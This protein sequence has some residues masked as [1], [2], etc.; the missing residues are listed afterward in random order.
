MFIPK[1]F[2]FRI[3][4][5]QLDIN[6]ESLIGRDTT[7]NKTENPNIN[8]AELINSPEKLRSRLNELNI[9]L[10]DSEQNK[11]N[12]YN[13][14]YREYELLFQ[15]EAPAKQLQILKSS[16][17]PD[18]LHSSVQALK[19]IQK[20]INQIC[21]TTQN[22]DSSKLPEIELIMSEIL[23]ESNSRRNDILQMGR[24]I[25]LKLYKSIET[26]WT[27]PHEKRLH[28]ALP[29]IKILTD[30]MELMGAM[31]LA[32]NTQEEYHQLFYEHQKAKDRRDKLIRDLDKASNEYKKE[33][34]NINKKKKSFLNKFFGKSTEQKEQ[35]IKEKFKKVNGYLEELNNSRQTFPFPPF[36]PT[37]K[38]TFKTPS[39]KIEPSKTKFKA[40]PRPQYFEKLSLEERIENFLT[41]FHESLSNYKKI[42]PNRQKAIK[43]FN[44]AKTEEEKE[45]AKEEI[46]KWLNTE[47][48]LD[49]TERSA[50]IDMLQESQQIITG[51]IYPKGRKFKE[52]DMGI[53]N[54]IF[55]QMDKE[56]FNSQSLEIFKIEIEYY[57][58]LIVIKDDKNKISTLPEEKQAK[59]VAQA[60]ALLAELEI[61][62]SINPNKESSIQSVYWGWTNELKQN[63]IINSS[64][65]KITKEIQETITIGN[66]INKENIEKHL[67]KFN[68]LKNKLTSNL[69]E[70]LSIIPKPHRMPNKQQELPSALNYLNPFLE[71]NIKE[72]NPTLLS[73]EVGAVIL[74]VE[75]LEKNKE[76]KDP[77]TIIEKATKL[78]AKNRSNNSKEIKELQSI[79][80][81]YFDSDEFY[82]ENLNSMWNQ[83]TTEV[84]QFNYLLRESKALIEFKS[85]NNNETLKKLQN[86]CKEI[87]SKLD[88]ETMEKALLKE[89]NKIK[90]L[91]L[92][93]RIP[94]HPFEI[95][96]TQDILDQISSIRKGAK[97]LAKD[98]ISRSNKTSSPDPQQLTKIKNLAN[99][100]IN[101]ELTQIDP[102]IRI[103]TLIETIIRESKELEINP[104]LNTEYFALNDR[105]GHRM[106][107]IKALKISETYIEQESSK[108]HKSKGYE[109]LKLVRKS[110]F[111]QR[112]I[113]EYLNKYGQNG[114]EKYLKDSIESFKR[115]L[116][117]TVLSLK[118]FLETT[119][120]LP[121]PIHNL[122]ECIEILIFESYMFITENEAQGISLKKYGSQELANMMKQIQSKTY[123]PYEEI[124]EN[125]V[126]ENL[127]S[128][129]LFENLQ[130]PTESTNPNTPPVPKSFNHEAFAPTLQG[131]EANT[132][133]PPI[134]TPPPAAHQAQQSLPA[135][136]HF[137][138]PDEEDQDQINT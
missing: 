30:K 15:L 37:K 117:L 99:N 103:S 96:D 118:R 97:E 61:Y 107:L 38:T 92:E 75:L 72:Y 124:D 14:L 95:N 76:N 138:L 83:D 68:Q 104:N 136:G 62:L 77:F 19:E 58:D 34:Q 52:E 119:I 60:E 126:Q 10:H 59:I 122:N 46:Q 36:Q 132:S 102:E 26:Y 67:D 40:S 22:I 73:P 49:S 114:L 18:N 27:L 20:T 12:N 66:K 115:E 94:Q 56:Y 106:K 131:I 35:E 84:S 1:R 90:N 11:T 110:Y 70:I 6:I 39:Q 53:I 28:R 29:I 21:Q 43:Q 57:I 100:I 87:E 45:K 7:P 135:F 9:Q 113:A 129:D 116:N 31:A 71:E 137:Q 54:K 98:I 93:L 127:P 41:R 32:T 88:L 55:Q 44:E 101:D 111:S 109:E 64:H 81:N 3:N 33:L 5:P 82:L 47:K 130:F 74:K 128:G 108:R 48:E 91:Q 78:I 24:A 69:D 25:N 133:T 2:L 23:E 63:L 4:N 125:P 85:I 51:E 134:E 105:H 112:N 65:K 16:W 86:L 50:V 79:V 80:S 89:V 8:I 17:N 120:Q 13:D 123:I 121:T 42:T